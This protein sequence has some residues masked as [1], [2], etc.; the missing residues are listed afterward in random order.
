M[1]L[2]LLSRCCCMVATRA[3][4]QALIASNTPLSH[5]GILELVLQFVGSGEGL[6]MRIVDKQWRVCY[7]E[8]AGP[9][10]APAWPIIYHHI[11]SCRCTKHR[12][13]LASASRVRSVPHNQICMC[14][15][16]IN[17]VSSSCSDN[18]MVLEFAGKLMIGV[19]QPIEGSWRAVLASML[20][21]QL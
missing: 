11:C 21:Y 18:F 10:K 19:C 12:A 14:Y 17:S 4:K 6:F 20:T 9:Y 3:Q 5:A 7:E 8:L 1:F 13:V 2:A 15:S 16:A